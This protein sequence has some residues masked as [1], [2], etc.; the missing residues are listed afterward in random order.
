M[1]YRQ[2]QLDGSDSG[3][4]RRVRIAVDE[5]PIGVIF[6]EN[7]LHRGEHG[8]G[9]LTVFARADGQVDI[10]VVNSEVS[11]EHV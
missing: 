10:W 9:L 3:R 7:P 6:L 4:E 2:V 8:A 5:N 11:E 1:S